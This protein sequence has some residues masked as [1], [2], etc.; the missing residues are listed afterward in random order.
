LY[1]AFS[2]SYEFHNV[3]SLSPARAWERRGALT[4]A[5]RNVA[6]TEAVPFPWTRSRN[7]FKPPPLRP[8]SRG[9]SLVWLGHRLAKAIR[10]VQIPRTALALRTRTAAHEIG[11]AEPR[12]RGGDP[13]DR[14]LHAAAPGPSDRGPRL[15]PAAHE[16]RRGADPEGG[17]A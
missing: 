8:P 7:L 16:Q 5:P 12:D 4:K 2:P 10:R 13:D 9:A 15:P 1:P 11:D 3:P 14:H 17:R 6:W